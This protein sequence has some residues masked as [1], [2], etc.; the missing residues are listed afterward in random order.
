M[1][2]IHGGA[3]LMGAGSEEA[4]RGL[5]LAAYRDVI[6]VTFNYRLGVL[7]FLSTGSY[8]QPVPTEENMLF[9]I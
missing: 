9:I 1:L 5:A 3:F 4:Y 7:G 8:P 6:V 2:Y